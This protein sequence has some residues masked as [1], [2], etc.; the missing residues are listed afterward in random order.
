[1]RLNFP[2]TVLAFLAALWVKAIYPASS[3][4]ADTDFYWHVTYGQWMLENRMLPPGD[5]F[6]WT[7]NGAPYQLTQWLGELAMG[8]AYNVAEL[9]GKKA[10]SVL[11]ATLSLAGWKQAN[12]V[13]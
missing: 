13:I 9:D 12:V 2:A 6:S 7:F 4:I 5:T 11:Q 10:L 1:M 8:L 3:G